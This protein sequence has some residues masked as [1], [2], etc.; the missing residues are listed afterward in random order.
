MFSKRLLITHYLG[1]VPLLRFES[2]WSPT[3]QACAAQKVLLVKPE[4]I[5]RVFFP[6]SRIIHREIDERAA[7]V[8]LMFNSLFASTDI[9]L[10]ATFRLAVE[11][12]VSLNSFFLNSITQQN[13]YVDKMITPCVMLIEQC[14][15]FE[16][17]HKLWK[18]SFCPRS[19]SVG[20]L[21]SGA[22]GVKS[23][24]TIQ[25]HLPYYL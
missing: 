13:G 20:W 22:T 18:I 17:S 19:S 15:M 4:S 12:G 10:N 14:G 9:S 24:E 11:M 16:G 6:G 21:D 23:E 25:T 3:T 8:Y 7:L 5:D 1:R 2:S